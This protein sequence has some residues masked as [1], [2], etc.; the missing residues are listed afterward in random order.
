[1]LWQQTFEDKSFVYVTQQ[2]FAL[3]PQVNFP[4]YNLNFHWRLSFKKVFYFNNEFKSSGPLTVSKNLALV[5]NIWPWVN[6]MFSI[7]SSFIPTTQIAAMLHHFSPLCCLYEYSIFIDCR[8]CRT[9][10]AG[11]NEQATRILIFT[12]YFL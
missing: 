12:G 8:T 1:M 10:N 6:F 3:L 11:I 7:L 2:C 9:C 4:T 5:W